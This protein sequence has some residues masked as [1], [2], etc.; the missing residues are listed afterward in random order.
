M[1]QTHINSHNRAACVLK[2]HNSNCYY[3]ISCCSPQRPAATFLH[4]LPPLSLRL[5]EGPTSPAGAQRKQN[6]IHPSVYCCPIRQESSRTASKSQ[7]GR[8]GHVCVWAGGRGQSRVAMKI[9]YCFPLH[10]LWWCVA[11][12]VGGCLRLVQIA[13]TQPRD[14][15]KPLQIKASTPTRVIGLATSYGCCWRS[16]S[17]IKHP[18]SA[19]CS[20]KTR[21]GQTLVLSSPSSA[22]TTQKSRLSS[23]ALTYLSQ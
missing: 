4:T 15:K 19:P 14:F 7:H 20:D 11:R 23:V 22:K 18:P 12:P 17:V 16:R 9:S 21:V 3:C 5:T 2:W 1:A 13:V 10:S 6:V 8:P